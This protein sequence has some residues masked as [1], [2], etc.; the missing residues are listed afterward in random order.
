MKILTIVIFG[1]LATGC[2]GATGDINSTSD[3]IKGC[4]YISCAIV[5]HAIISFFR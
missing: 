5:T 1:L 3:I 2:A 4:S